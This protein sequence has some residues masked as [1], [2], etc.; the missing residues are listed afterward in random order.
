[1]KRYGLFI[2]GKWI[3]ATTDE[4]FEVTNPATGEIVGN[5]ADGGEADVERA[6][7]AAH[8][9]FPAW[10]NQTAKERAEI[11]RRAYELMI[12]HKDELGEIMTLE[13]GKPILEAKGEIQY[14]A[15][16]VEW[17]G[18]EAKR[19]YGETIPA[20]ATDKR[21]WVHKQPVG[22]AAAITP[23]NFPASMITRKIAP[24]LAAGCTVVIK[25]AQQTPLTACR[26]V[27]L[28]HEAGVPKGV[29][30]LITSTHAS[31]VGEALLKDERVRK[32]GFTGSTA[33]GKV[34]M[35]QA[36]DTM[37]KIS[38]ELGGH[39]PFIVFADADLDRAVDEVL[40]SKFRNAGQTCVCANRIYVEQSIGQ[41]F[42]ERLAQKTKELKVGNGMEEGVAIG[43][44]IDS[45]AADKVEGQ[46]K[47]A[48]NKGAKVMTGG[49]RHTKVGKHP[50]QKA[51][52]FEP[53]VLLDV[54]DEMEVMR[55]E[56][57][58][59]VAPI[60]Y[61]SS[62]EEAI[63]KANH[64]RYGLAAYFYTENLARA[65]RVSEK[66]EFGIVGVND[67]TPSTA[68][69]PFGGFKESGLGREGGKYGVEEY[70]ETK[71]ISVRI[72]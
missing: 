20:S 9:A 46:V 65:I 17:S 16:F 58:G 48:V 10:S 63:A 44:L 39:A 25:P 24:A 8:E 32:V 27:E 13:Q 47:D 18:E 70:L 1:M 26:I 29:I 22:V 68:Q 56:T 7:T 57:F 6:I 52:F 45:A 42:A 35:K 33:I 34:L 12:A 28:F 40:S 62:E 43:P 50:G 59:P 54:T 60:Q 5:C 49:H 3:E 37:K 66:L 71:Y 2:N 72:Q 55:E 51:H 31:T 11:L 67:G 41:A 61:F 30:N 14:A 38:L 15:D 21:I 23:W 36:A 53:T 64:S 69:A 4:R 19:I